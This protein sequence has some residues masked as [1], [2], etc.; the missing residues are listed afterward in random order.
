MLRTELL[1]AAWNYSLSLLLPLT[2]SSYLFKV[3]LHSRVWLAVTPRVASLAPV[4][5]EGAR[6]SIGK[7]KQSISHPECTSHG[8]TQAHTAAAIPACSCRHTQYT[9]AHTRTHIITGWSCQVVAEK[10]TTRKCSCKCTGSLPAFALS[11]PSSAPCLSCHPSPLHISTTPN[12]L[13]AT[14]TT[15]RTDSQ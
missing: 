3:G 13:S 12:P 2:H 1:P 5:V 11:S 10:D 15:I 9:H 8:V 7:G 6:T 14:T 4:Q